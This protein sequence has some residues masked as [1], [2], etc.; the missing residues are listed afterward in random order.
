MLPNSPN[1]LCSLTHTT[2]TEYTTTHA[3]TTDGRP[4]DDESATTESGNARIH[5]EFDF[6]EFYSLATR[7]LD[8]DTNSIANLNSLKNRWELTFKKTTSS[9][10]SI[11]DPKQSSLKPVAGRV[12][13]PFRSRVSLLPRRNVLPPAESLPVEDV[14]GHIGDPTQLA[15]VVHDSDMDDSTAGHTGTVQNG[16]NQGFSPSDLTLPAKILQEKTSEQSDIFIGTVKLLSNPV[17]NIATAFLQSSRKTL[18]FV[19][20]TKQNGEIVV[21]PSKEVAAAGSKKW[22]A[23]AG[24][25]FWGQPIVLQVW[26]QGMSL[27]RQKHTQ[28]PVWIRLKHLP[29]EYWTEDGLS[30]VASGVGTPLYTDGI[31]RECSRLD[32]AR[33]CVML[34]YNSTLPKHLILISP[35][36]RDGK[37]DPR[38][39]DI[40]YEWLPLRCKNCCSLG[41]IAS[42]C[43][44]NIKKPIVPPI[45]V[46]VQK[47]SA[48]SASVQPI[49]GELEAGV[50]QSKAAATSSPSSAQP[51]QVDILGEGQPGTIDDSRGKNLVLHNSFDALDEEHDDA[52]INSDDDNRLPGP[53]IC[54]PQVGV[55]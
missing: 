28:I 16:R 46:F 22:L 27:R 17:D 15:G 8:G 50:F 10:M 38:R 12:G 48:Q 33:V 35:F 37:E 44:D 39:V 6:E 24:A 26:E 55:P 45:T 31:T 9:E 11:A 21:R 2:H 42:S 43:P 40:E 52:E 34:D 30:T 3:A 53:N 20:P 7:V 47:Q 51:A 5:E 4:D 32:F 29:M 49:M 1:S 19:P 14:L 23:T 36:L 41:H 18:H 13:T 25:I 54:S